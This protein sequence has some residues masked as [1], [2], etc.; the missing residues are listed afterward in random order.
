VTDATYDYDENGN[1]LTNTLEGNNR[2]TN[3]GTYT[4]Q[5]DDEGNRTL[6]TNIATG[7]TTDYVWDNRNR[8]VSITDKTSGGS[9]TKTVEYTYDA[10]DHRIA[11]SITTAFVPTCIP[12]IGHSK[13]G[14]PQ[15]KPHKI[16]FASFGL[17]A[18]TFGQ[19]RATP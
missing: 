18:H 16:R 15:H 12:R 7:A 3:D 2:V 9:V 19:P 8:L 14:Q 6:R 11:K 5:Y 17:K 13:F 4:Y 1:R 10:F